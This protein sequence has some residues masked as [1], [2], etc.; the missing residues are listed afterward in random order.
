[1]TPCLHEYPPTIERYL[2][3]A[4]PK[5]MD[6][7]IAAPIGGALIDIPSSPPMLRRAQTHSPQTLLRYSR[8]HGRCGRS[9]ELL[10]AEKA[11]LTL[12]V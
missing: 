1:M 12:G 5:C 7:I 3:L 6:A 2:P 10:F 4:S 11:I 9:D 8:I